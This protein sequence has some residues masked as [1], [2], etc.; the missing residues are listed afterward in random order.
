MDL[1]IYTAAADK[2]QAAVTS[3]SDTTPVANLEQLVLGD[4]TPLTLKFTNGTSYESWSG[5]AGYTV[6]VGLGGLDVNGANAYASSST[7]STITN[8]WS[9]R[10]DLA[11]Q[12]LIDAL[13][14]QVGNAVDWSRY[15]Y[16]SRIPGPR[17][18]LGWFFLQIAVTDPSGNLVSYSTLRVS[19]RNRVLPNGLPAATVVPT[20]YGV[21]TYPDVTG[22]VSA[23][24][25]ATKLGGLTS[26]NVLPTGMVVILN[27]QVTITDDG[28]TH[29]G[30]MTLHFQLQS[31]TQA[32]ASPLWVRPYDYNAS[33]NARVWRLIGAFLDTCP[34]SWNAV[35]S[36]FHYV[37]LY[38]AA[39][40]V[41]IYP[42]QIGT[43]APA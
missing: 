22:L 11:T 42:D 18:A 40:E 39:G 28:G 24:A 33:T 7:F 25:D 14:L 29:T 26:A 3:V 35:T 21:L 10:L 38:G 12:R 16:Q 34:A 4:S 31:S 23:G 5:Q 37:I 36:K 6:F 19:V 15:P 30:T 1:I 41:G 2:S 17:P 43:A 9:G 32:T 27:F 20:L 8:G 13:A